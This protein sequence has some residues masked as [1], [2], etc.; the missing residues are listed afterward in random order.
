MMN[1]LYCQVKIQ[2]IFSFQD[3]CLATFFQSLLKIKGEFYTL[4]KARTFFME[5]ITSFTI[6]HIKLQPGCMFPAR[7]RLE[8][9]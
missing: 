4:Q 6:D 3:S 8:T 2:E 5:K 1:R 7:I 9:A